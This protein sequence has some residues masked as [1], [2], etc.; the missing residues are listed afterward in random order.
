MYMYMYYT[1]LSRPGDKTTNVKK[2]LGFNYDDCL[3]LKDTCTCRYMY[4]YTSGH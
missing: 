2:V 3:Q 1:A 4:M